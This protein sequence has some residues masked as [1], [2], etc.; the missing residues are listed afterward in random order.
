MTIKKPVYTRT[1]FFYALAPRDL[2][3]I[4]GIFCL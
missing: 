2:S 4:F 3:K 1:G